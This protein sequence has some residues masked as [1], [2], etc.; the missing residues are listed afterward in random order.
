MDLKQAE[1]LCIELMKEH[2]LTSEGWRFAYN[3]RTRAAGICS[4]RKKTI[5]LSSPLTLGGQEDEVRDTILHEIAHALTPGHGHDH[6]W[7][8]KAK[9][10]GCDGSRC[11]S[12][13]T[14]PGYAKTVQTLSK[15]RGSCPN[16]HFFFV[17]RIPKR[18]RTCGTCSKRFDLK[19][20]IEY[21]VNNPA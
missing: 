18:V 20:K 4:V 7:V 2:G 10:L 9:Q 17:N 13:L 15:Y 21:S 14:K 3:K 6:V 11:Y 16:G 19:Y 5:F 8:A 1:D 12:D